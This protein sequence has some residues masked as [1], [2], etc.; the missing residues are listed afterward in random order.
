MLK[1]KIT[2]KTPAPAPEPMKL[3]APERKL[4]GEDERREDVRKRKGRSSLRIDPQT[5]GVS[6]NGG[7]GINIPM[8]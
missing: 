5:G 4:G 3:E 6:S 8:K 2:N 7:A 1:P